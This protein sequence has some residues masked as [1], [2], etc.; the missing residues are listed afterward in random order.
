[1]AK[2]TSPRHPKN[3]SVA[4][5]PPA[6]NTGFEHLSVL[7]KGSSVEP[8]PRR[9]GLSEPSRKGGAATAKAEPSQKGGAA[10]APRCTSSEAAAKAEP[11][12]QSAIAA[13]MAQQPTIA[14]RGSCSSPAAGSGGAGAQAAPQ[15]PCGQPLP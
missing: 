9:N 10:A 8:E 4:P 2:K 12:A 14:V 7:P 5:M 6:S 3:G 15:Q 1:M 13:R 11:Q